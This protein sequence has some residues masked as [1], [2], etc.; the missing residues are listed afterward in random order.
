M[1]TTLN[2][3]PLAVI[4]SLLCWGCEEIAEPE[5]DDTTPP[6][7]ELTCDT[8][9]DIA[10]FELKLEVDVSDNEAVKS[11]DFVVNDSIVYHATSKP[12]STTWTPDPSVI[13]TSY[14]ALAIAVD[15]VGNA[16]LSDILPLQFSRRTLDITRSK[17]TD[18]DHWG[19]NFDA[20]VKY[21]VFH[22]VNRYSDPVSWNISQDN[23]I[24]LRFWPVA[25]TLQPGEQIAVLVDPQRENYS[26]TGWHY[27]NVQLASDPGVLY[28]QKISLQ[29]TDII[30][31]D[32]KLFGT[33]N[34]EQG[35][36]LLNLHPDT[37]LVIGSSTG[38]MEFY[39]DYLF[40]YGLHV[41]SVNTVDQSH[42]HR[43][44]RFDQFDGSRE[45]FVH[46]AWLTTESDLIVAGSVHFLGEGTDFEFLLRT[47]IDGELIWWTDI[48]GWILS[49]DRRSDGLVAVAA[50]PDQNNRKILFVQ[51][52]GSVSHET[53]IPVNLGYDLSFY[54][55]DQLLISG[56]GELQCL[57][58]ATGSIEWTFD[59]DGNYY[60][61]G[62]YLVATD[63]LHNI[64]LASW[65]WY[66]QDIFSLYKLVDNQVIWHTERTVMDERIRCILAAPDGSIFYGGIDQVSQYGV[67]FMF[68][69]DG[70]YGATVRFQDY[71]SGINHLAWSSDG[72]LLITGWS[73][74]YLP[75]INNGNSDIVYDTFWPGDIEAYSFPNR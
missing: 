7:V 59:D 22:L 12:W 1:K 47:T 70:S 16:A 46:D 28:E 8:Y 23:P 40:P 15:E 39:P 13:D 69:A 60:F 35:M 41:I 44:I 61:R 3:T 73:E 9:N 18:S 14:L 11:V 20:H 31:G 75:S 24:M 29:V 21:G 33:G 53:S 50:A 67:I 72:S 71:I 54:R 25:G 68:D 66:D 57:S 49:A 17:G 65:Y 64:Y 4:L 55:D 63:Y 34:Y 51:D 48:D 37:V 2:L 42:Q 36:K 38:H 56:N 10:F 6:S 5:I 74:D 26:A 52:D 62:N 45:I 43:L 19:W 58:V 27:S 32:L 30:H